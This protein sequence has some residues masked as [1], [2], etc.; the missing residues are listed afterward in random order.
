MSYDGEL[1]DSC[2]AI[3]LDLSRAYVVA[4]SGSGPNVCGH[5]LFHVNSGGGHYFHVAEIHGRP[6]HLNQP[7][8]LRYLEENG[9]TEIRSVHVPLS[10][11]DEALRYLH[12]L[13]AGNWTWLV[14]PNNC[15]AFCEEIIKAGGGDWSSWSNCPSVATQPTIGQRATEFMMELERSIYG[16]YRVPRF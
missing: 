14:L 12:T 16:L 3:D 6:R 9:K 4:V 10:K 5:L 8:Y 15:V 11:P 7:G 13:M 1:M 2:G